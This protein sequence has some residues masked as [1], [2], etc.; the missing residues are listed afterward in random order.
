MGFIG[1]L[2]RLLVGLALFV[3]VLMLGIAFAPQLA[4]LFGSLPGTF[5]F[6]NNGT[7]VQIPV[8]A[9]IVASVV[10]TLIVNLIALPF[11]RRNTT[12]RDVQY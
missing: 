7:T 6:T 11:R 9:S 4:T 12:L 8:L 10:L 1:S 2:V 5:T 3:V